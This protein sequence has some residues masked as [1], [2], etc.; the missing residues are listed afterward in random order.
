MSTGDSRAFCLPSDIGFTDKFIVFI[1][2]NVAL[3]LF[4]ESIEMNEIPLFQKGW[5]MLPP[6][7]LLT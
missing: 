1:L 3:T 7:G 2:E 6:L 4:C 5:F